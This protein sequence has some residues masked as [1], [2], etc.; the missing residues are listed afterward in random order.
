M[1]QVLSG[2]I[3]ARAVVGG[4]G[5]GAG[6]GSTRTRGRLERTAHAA[7]GTAH[8]R[9]LAA[10]SDGGDNVPA[11]L[12]AAGAE[13][14]NAIAHSVGRLFHLWLFSWHENKRGVC[15]DLSQH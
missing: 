13:L 7:L 8:P 14:V 11:L 4:A 6:A 15:G 3:S 9:D 5:F 2:P 1:R 10:L 12:L